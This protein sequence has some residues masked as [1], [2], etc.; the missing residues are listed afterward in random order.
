MFDKSFSKRVG[1]KTET[2]AVVGRIVI[3]NTEGSGDL[4]LPLIAHEVMEFLR[5]GGAFV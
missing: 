4:N 1:L 3:E 5:S 2:Q